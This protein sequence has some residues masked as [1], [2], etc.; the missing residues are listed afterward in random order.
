M[1]VEHGLNPVD[2]SIIVYEKAILEELVP[3]EVAPET[4]VWPWGDRSSAEV[5]GFTRL[6]KKFILEWSRERYRGC[7]FEG[8]ARKALR[9]KGI[10]DEDKMSCLF[11]K[12]GLSV[13]EASAS[14]TAP[15]EDVSC[16]WQ[17]KEGFDREFKDHCR[18]VEQEEG[19]KIT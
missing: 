19:P 17:S 12:L 1:M 13:E 18:S 6:E 15:I 16:P 10:L 11:S 2:I 14:D 4:I 9:E 7:F 5:L 8:P 3:L